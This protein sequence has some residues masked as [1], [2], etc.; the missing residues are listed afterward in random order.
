MRA[1]SIRQPW[2]E[3]ILLG[4]KTIEVRSQ[5]TNIRERVHIYAG[6]NRIEAEEEARIADQFG[7]DV[8]GLAPWRPGGHGRDRRLPTLG[9]K[10]QRGCG[11]R[12][13]PGGWL[14]RLAP[15]TTRAG[16]ES[17]DSEETPPAGVLQPVLMSP[18]H[19]G[20]P[21]DHPIALAAATDYPDRGRQPPKRGRRGLEWD[22]KCCLFAARRRRSLRYP[23]DETKMHRSGASSA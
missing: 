22:G 10:R 8:D 11:L 23:A 14:L 17:S 15:G 1:L 21:L 16:R 2:A 12:D 13:R 9:D 4:H 19:L 5:R 18:E 20:L 7:I 6:R 3:L